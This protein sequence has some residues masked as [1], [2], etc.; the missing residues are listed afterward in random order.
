VEK[1]LALQN[2]L[3]VFRVLKVPNVALPHPWIGTNEILSLCVI[4]SVLIKIT[5]VMKHY[6][7]GFNELQY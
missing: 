3:I 1:K 2:V 7:I 6:N 4:T 5:F